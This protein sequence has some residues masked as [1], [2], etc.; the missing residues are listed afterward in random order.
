[1]LRHHRMA[2]LSRA[3]SCL[4]LRLCLHRHIQVLA[5]HLHTPKEGAEAGPIF[6]MGRLQVVR[7]EGKVRK[8]L[9]LHLHTPAGKQEWH[10]HL[11]L[12]PSMHQHQGRHPTECGPVDLLRPMAR[13]C[14]VHTC[15][16]QTCLVQT[17]Q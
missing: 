8:G 2:S 17:C 12:H 16:E 6:R 15:L 5:P 4:R 10:R 1:M 7:L 14:L 13:K 9:L 11:V 3:E